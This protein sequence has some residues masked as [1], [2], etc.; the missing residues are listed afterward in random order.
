MHP[1]QSL[2][3]AL[4]I[5]LAFALLGACTSPIS[6]PVK[7]RA[8]KREAQALM[9]HYPIKRPKDWTGVP[10]S[11]WPPTIASLKPQSV[12]AH[13]WGID[14]AVQQYFD[15]GWGYAVPRNNGYLPMPAYC[16]SEPCQ[17]VFW[18]GPC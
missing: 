11:E 10:I 12:T 7:L 9:A 8:V 4:A 13:H 18:H 16:Y 2:I 6:D 5:P 15:G 1:R 14:I 3:A 17:S